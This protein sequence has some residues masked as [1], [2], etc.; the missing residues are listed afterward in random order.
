MAHMHSEMRNDEGTMKAG[1]PATQESSPHPP[2]TGWSKHRVEALT[3]G[4]FAVAMTLLVIDLK[5]PDHAAI[6]TQAELLQELA[7]LLPKAISWL[8]SFF[9]LAIFWVGHHRMLHHVRTVDE[10]LLWRNILQLALVSLIPFS[11]A[12]IGEYGG[13]FASQVVYSGNMMALGLVSLWKAHY[14]RLHPEL[15][16][17]PMPEGAYHAARIRIGGLVLIGMVALAIARWV[18]P[19]YA[20]MAYMLMFPIGRYSRLIEARGASGR[21]RT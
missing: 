11:S 18:T 21:A 17:T 3:D 20:T 14:I 15:C 19:L 6:H 1:T 2:A 4:I 13:A 10:G 5:L 9:V 8:I 7:N 16:H 12:I